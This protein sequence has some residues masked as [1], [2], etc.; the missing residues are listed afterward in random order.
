LTKQRAVEDFAASA[1]TPTLAI[2]DSPTARDKIESGD[3]AIASLHKIELS[4]GDP[5]SEAVVNAR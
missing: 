4:L 5:V 1:N 3:S 2:A